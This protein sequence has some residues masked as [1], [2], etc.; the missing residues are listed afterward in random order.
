[1]SKAAPKDRPQRSTNSPPKPEGPPHTVLSARAATFVEL[2]LSEDDLGVLVILFSNGLC[3]TDKVVL[4][5]ACSARA[6]IF[7]GAKVSLSPPK[8]RP[9]LV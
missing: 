5:A 6:A 7:G 1:M 2:M 4:Q 9:G 8:I 3:T